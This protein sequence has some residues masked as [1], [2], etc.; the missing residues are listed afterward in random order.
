MKVL[1]LSSPSNDA[2][3]FCCLNVQTQ[4]NELQ[5]LADQVYEEY[6]EQ[7]RRAL[8]LA[9]KIAEL[10]EQVTSQKEKLQGG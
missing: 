6:A 1:F 2:L 3:L 9:T 7:T 8:D 10:E 5:D 4:V